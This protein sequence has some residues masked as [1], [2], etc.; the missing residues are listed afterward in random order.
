[1][2]RNIRDVDLA[3]PFVKRLADQSARREQTLLAL[4]DS[5]AF[6]REELTALASKVQLYR[7]YA[8]QRRAGAG[9]S[10]VWSWRA[11][12][13]AGRV[14]VIEVYLS[15]GS[16]ATDDY[17]QLSLRDREARIL[18]MSPY[19]GRKQARNF[20]R[21][22]E[23]FLMAA[24]RV[25]RWINA[26]PDDDLAVLLPKSKAYG[27]DRWL[28]AVSDACEARS[29][30]AGRVVERFFSLDEELNDLVFEF[31]EA[32]QPVRFRSIICRRECSALDPLSPSEPRYRVVEFFDRRT[33]RRSSREVSA[34][35][36]RLQVTK[37]QERLAREVGRDLSPEEIE[38]SR[39][40]I[41]NRVP[42]PRLT[43]ELISHCHLGK[44]S[45]SILDHQKRMAAVMDEWESCRT[46]IRSLL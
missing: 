29:S 24:Q 8:G 23:R 31:N 43:D 13:R 44:H 40:F 45:H 39:R 26:F 27:L 14:S 28:E 20:S 36:R 25:V 5:M 30:V 3:G 19:L 18:L 11:S 7:G 1:M 38:T 6:A 33:G 17:K 10:L 9:W 32:R 46:L 12:R 37:A 35:K 2:R 41:R 15:I 22:L 4:L 21:D 34:Y 16:K 42:S